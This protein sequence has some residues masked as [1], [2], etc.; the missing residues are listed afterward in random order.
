ME[1]AE[2]GLTAKNAEN[3]KKNQSLR[4]LRSRRLNP[5][6]LTFVL[7]FSVFAGDALGQ[8][9][10]G[11]DRPEAWAMKYFTS[12]TVL[13][14]LSTPDTLPPGSMALQF[15]SGWLPPLSAAQQR[16]GFNGATPED[17]NKA[18]VFMRPRV[19]VG[20]PGRMAIVVGVDPPV[21]TF[22]VTPRLVAVGIEGPL[23]DSSTWRLNW[24]AHGQTGSVTAAVTC[25]SS[26]LTFAPG[27]G[28]NPA[29]CTAESADVTTLRYAG[30][31]LQL[32]RRIGQRVLPHV[33]VGGHYIDNVFQTNAETFGQPD[34]TRMRA[35]GFAF[36]ASA[37]L[38]YALSQRLAV[39]ADL[40]YA[41][42]TVRRTPAS[43]MSLDPMINGRILVSYRVIK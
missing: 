31:E 5:L 34:R 19:A 3:A 40:F 12:A 29:G 16:V 26:V 11:F 21:R 27:S 35:S 9:R 37:G 39:S 6:R 28:A 13:S 41:P 32:A 18:P 8:E 25:P 1:N 36:A 42:L 24:R 15:E 2:K 4:S 20:L 23:Y 30:V 17:L 38:G 43:A 22:G 33:A 7:A 14:G 10:I